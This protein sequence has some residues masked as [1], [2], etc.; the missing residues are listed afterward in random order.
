MQMVLSILDNGSMINNMD[1]VRKYGQ[2]AL[3][4]KDIMKMGWN[5]EKVSLFYKMVAYMMENSPKMILKAKETIGGQMEISIKDS[6]WRIRS[7][8]KVCLYTKIKRNMKDN[9][10]LEN[11]KAM[12][13]SLGLMAENTLV[14][15][16]M[17]SNTGKELC[18]P[19]ME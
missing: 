13:F 17:A 3:G 2:M 14:N 15:G 8:E 7:T 6:G 11:E 16:K 9:F 19:Q 10:S 1:Q 5:M 4:M 18:S 12:V